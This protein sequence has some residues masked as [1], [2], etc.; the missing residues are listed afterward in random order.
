MIT[1]GSPKLVEGRTLTFKGGNSVK[2]LLVLLGL[3]LTLGLTLAQGEQQPT[4]DD[5]FV[6]PA[7]W[8]SAAP[9]EAKYGGEYRTF[10][11]SDFDS[12]N[13]FTVASSPDLPNNGMAQGVGLI[14]RDPT[15]PTKF[16]PW[17]AKSYEVSDDGLVYTFQLREGMKFSDG[18]EIT[19]QD[20]V[21]TATIHKDP[22]V[23]SN[24]YSTFFI[25]DAEVTVESPSKYVVVITFP[26][27][28]ATA[29]GKVSYTPWPTHIFGPV[30]EEGGAEAITEMWTLSGDVT[31]FVSPGPFVATRYAAGER[32]S[33]ARNP[34]YGTWNTDSEGNQLPYLDNLSFTLVKDLNSALASYLSGDL[35][36]FGIST[37][38]ELQQVQ[39]AVQGGQ[40]DATLWPNH[41]AN[42]SSSWIVFN[43]N[44]ANQPKKQALFRNQKFRQAMSHLVDRDAMVKL[45][46]GGLATPAYGSVYAVLSEWIDPELKTFAYDQAAAAK[47]L[48]E[49][50]YTEKDAQ[51]YLVNDAGERI[52]FNLVTN[53]GN[54]IREQ[55]VQIFADTAKEAGVQV[56]VRPIAFEVLV[57]QLTATG[58]ERG[59]DAILLGLVGGD[60]DWPFG[61]N[62]EPCGTNLHGY[63]VTADG[64]CL[65]PIEQ[66]INDL[67][68]E[69]AK[70]LDVEKRKQI[71]YQIQALQSELQGFIY[72]VSPADSPTWSNRVGGNYADEVM[73]SLTGNRDI[74]LTF[75]R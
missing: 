65:D 47:L 31:E 26:E 23:G 20:W 69:G 33:F 58:P 1:T 61:E 38:D 12:Y 8:S 57:N 41:G 52:S 25:G 18:V 2:K 56:N 19:G 60:Q 54:D 27:I 5:P 48:G 70:E 21:T 55:L 17:M 13:P 67:Y 22:D 29:L 11:I 34:Y 9:G 73:T 39:S 7:G 50:G 63:S 59:F 10:S 64:K 35:D 4:I 40:L 46:F 68:F 44:H 36:T 53:A 37:V 66:Q 49:I 15:D 51:G 71:G 30:Y 3:L 43:W 24:S 6:Y 62:V 28:S 32:A 42:A 45:V 74:N 14:Q 16:V 75:I 72:T